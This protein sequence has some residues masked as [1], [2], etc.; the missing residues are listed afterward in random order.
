MACEGELSFARN[1]V[2]VFTIGAQPLICPPSVAKMKRAAPVA[3]VLVAVVPV[4]MKSAP[5]ASAGAFAGTDSPRGSLCQ[6]WCSS[7]AECVTLGFQPS[8]S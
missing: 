4:T 3:V 2:A 6:R 7:D 1:A 8:F 5:R